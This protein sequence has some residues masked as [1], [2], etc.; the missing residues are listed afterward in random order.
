MGEF[1]VL[2]I[3]RVQQETQKHLPPPTRPPDHL[4]CVMDE[5]GEH[6]K[7]IRS[8]FKDWAKKGDVSLSDMTPQQREAAWDRAYDELADVLILSARA[9]ISTSTLERVW[10]LP[11]VLSMDD[12]PLYMVPAGNVMLGELM[13]NVVGSVAH[14]VLRDDAPSAISA[15]FWIAVIAARYPSGVGGLQR[16]WER[17]TQVVR[18]RVYQ[19][20]PPI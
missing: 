18:T 1:T 17:K 15:L 6:L 10:E 5:I 8:T 9:I 7:E 16:A 2:A 4:A 11:E 14:A 13:Y 19:S 20:P 3:L 12:A